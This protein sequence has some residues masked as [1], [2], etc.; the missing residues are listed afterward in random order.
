MLLQ[1]F[2]GNKR[3]ADASVEDDKKVRAGPDVSKLQKAI[4]NLQGQVRNLK[5][6]G[7]QHPGGQGPKG[8]KGRGKGKNNMIRMPPQLIGLS[9]TTEQG[10]SGMFA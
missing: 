6:A 3:K 8:K 4:E 2:Q 5:S 9:P 7:S 1:P 10:M